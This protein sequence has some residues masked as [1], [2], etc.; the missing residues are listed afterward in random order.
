MMSSVAESAALTKPATTA[1]WV[2]V[3]I[4]AGS[5]MFV[6]G[7][8]VSAAFAPEWRV[9]HVFQALIYVAV[10]VLTWKNSPWGFGAGFFVALFWNVLSLFTTLWQDAAREIWRLIRAGQLQRPDI[11]LSSFAACGHVLII[12]GC[13]VGFLRTRPGTRQ[14]GQFVAAG[15]V[16][17]L[18]LVAAVW[19]V[20]PPAAIA[21]FKRIF[22]L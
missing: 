13:I 7:L 15:V 22:G 19:T 6:F 18:Y 17:V 16:T 20:G 21:L 5:A 8:I 1:R 2:T 9:L 12:V 3:L 11:L 10:V 4:V 14:W